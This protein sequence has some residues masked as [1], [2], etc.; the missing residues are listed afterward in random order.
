[1]VGIALDCLLF[2]PAE[3]QTPSYRDKKWVLAI[4]GACLKKKVPHSTTSAACSSFS[5]EILW[6][7]LW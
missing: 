4:W 2:S 3:Q 7:T 5:H 6:G 1:M